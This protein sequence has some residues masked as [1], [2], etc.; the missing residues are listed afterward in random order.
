MADKCQEK[1]PDCQKACSRID[2]QAHA[3]GTPHAHICK[4]GRP[5]I[6]KTGDSSAITHIGPGTQV[7]IQEAGDYAV[8]KYLALSESLMLMGYSH[9][10]IGIIL[11]EMSLAYMEAACVPKDALHKLIDKLYK[12]LDGPNPHCPICGKTETHVH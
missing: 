10:T 7:Q 6:W 2:G 8:G 1:C 3:D 9:T 5:H 11:L 4:D 12:E